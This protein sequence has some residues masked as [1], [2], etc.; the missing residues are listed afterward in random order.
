MTV[1]SKCAFL[2]V[3]FVLCNFISFS[4]SQNIDESDYYPLKLG[5]YWDYSGQNF[6][7]TERIVETTTINGH[8]YY[9]L[10][11][12]SETEPE[13]WLRSQ[14][15]VVY[16]L[17]SRDSSEY[18]LFDFNAEAGK[19]WD[20][21]WGYECFF[22]GGIAVVGTADTITTPLG[23][24]TGYHFFHT[25]FCADAG[26]RESWFARGIGKVAYTEDNFIGMQEYQLN[27]YSITTSTIE[28][29]S[30]VISASFELYPNYPN[31]FNAETV[32]PYYLPTANVVTL[33][34]YDV[35]GREILTLVDNRQD[36]GYHLASFTAM[37]IPGGIYFYRLEIDHQIVST[38]KLLYLK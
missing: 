25:G 10:T 26:M 23:E 5:A 38:R 4:F 28:T 33:K 34:L 31:P 3:V 18:K 19:S 9:G 12:W 30:V 8:Q 15:N 29:K 16:M 13:F 14:N 32:I 17:Y 35:R 7:H 36:A 24:F 6:P 27:D 2:F 37:S 11:V 1:T 21:P 20:L 22:G